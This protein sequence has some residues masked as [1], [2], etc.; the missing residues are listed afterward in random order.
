MD[1]VEA[2]DRPLPGTV[3]GAV[4]LIGDDDVEVAGS[5]TR[6]RG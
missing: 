5:D 2:S 6:R 3:D 4:A 1:G